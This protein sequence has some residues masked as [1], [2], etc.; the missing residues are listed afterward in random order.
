MLLPE[1]DRS[2]DHELGRTDIRSRTQNVDGN[3]S[4][5]FELVT[6]A[7][8]I[9]EH[10]FNLVLGDHSQSISIPQR[11]LISYMFLGRTMASNK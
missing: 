3:E 10:I 2:M 5:N 9:K 4:G 11:M 6:S 7:P 1:E 8:R